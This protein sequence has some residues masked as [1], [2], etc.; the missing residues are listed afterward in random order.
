MRS[1][2]FNLSTANAT[3]WDAAVTLTEAYLTENTK[4]NQLL[5]RL[6]EGFRVIAEPL[7]S[8]YS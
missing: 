5:E 1:I 8:P 7:A 2:K 6:P 4:A 3:A